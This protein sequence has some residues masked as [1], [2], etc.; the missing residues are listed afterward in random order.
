MAFELRGV[1]VT[2]KHSYQIEYKY[3]WQCSNEICGAEFKRHSKSVDP[4][5]HTCGACRSRLV[6]IKPVPRKDAAGNT[7]GAVTGY[8]AY[9]KEQYAGIKAGLA[10]GATQKEVMEAIGRQYRAEKAKK[11]VVPVLVPASQLFRSSSTLS[12]SSVGAGK[13]KEL[14]DSADASQNVNGV[15]RVLEFITIADD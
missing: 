2:T 5:R 6:Q 10:K 4:K 1:E 7:T 14:L 13:A 15:A 9:V 12:S 3:T 8:A 11:A